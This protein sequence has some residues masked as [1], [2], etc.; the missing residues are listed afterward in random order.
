MNSLISFAAFGLKTSKHASVSTKMESAPP[1]PSGLISHLY[2][3]A[4]HWVMVVLLLLGIFLAEGMQPLLAQGSRT[5]Y[6]SGAT[7]RRAFLQSRPVEKVPATFNPFPNRGTHRVWV[8]EGETIYVGSSMQGLDINANT[9]TGTIILRTPNGTTY[10]SGTSTTVGLIAN[11]TEELAGPDRPGVTAGYTPYTRTVLAGEA[12]IWEID[13]VSM[14]SATTNSGGNGTNFTQHTTGGSPDRLFDNDFQA[15]FNWSGTGLNG[16]PIVENACALILAW[17]VSVTSGPTSGTLIEGRVFFTN[18]TLTLPNNYPTNGGFYGKTYLLTKEG[19]SYSIEGNNLNGAS[20][21]VFS[22]N[23]GIVSGGTATP[24]QGTTGGT[25]TYLSEDEVTISGAD[26][27]NT[28]DPRSADGSTDFTNLQFYTKPASD[29]PATAPIRYYNTYASSPGV[30]IE[31]NKWIKNTPLTIT[32]SNYTITDVTT[33]LPNRVGPAGANVGFTTN[34]AGRY[35]MDIDGNDDGDFTDPIDRRIL[36]NAIVGANTFFWDGKDGN[37]NALASNVTPVLRLEQNFLGEIHIPMVDVEINPNGIIV[38]RLDANYDPIPGQDLL[39]WNDENISNSTVVTNPPYPSNPVTNTVTGLSSTTNGH[40]FGAEVPVTPFEGCTSCSATLNNGDGKED[41]GNGKIINS[42]TRVGDLQELTLEVTPL[43][44]AALGIVKTS[45]LPNATNG[46]T[47]TYT[48]TVTGG[49]I[50]TANNVTLTDVLPSGLTYVANSTV[51]SI[52]NATVVT[53]RARDEFASQAY[54]LNVGTVNFSS[55][56]IESGTGETPTS[57]SVGTI[58]VNT[59]NGNLQFQGTSSSPAIDRGINLSTATSAT[60]SFNQNTTAL[61]V[62]ETLTFQMSSNG[63]TYNTINTFRGT[64]GLY[65]Y[66]VPN[67]YFTANARIRFIKSSWS[68]TVNDNVTIDN[69]EVEYSASSTVTTTRNNN[70]SGTQLNSGLPATLITVADNIDLTPSSV[71]T[72]TFMYTVG[73]ISA[74]TFVNTATANSTD[75]ASSVSATHTSNYSNAAPTFTTSC[76]ADIDAT[77]VPGSCNVTLTIPGVVATDDC[78]SPTITWALT[79]ATTGNGTG[80][81][82]SKTFLPGETLITYTATDNLGQTVTCSFTVTVD[83]CADL[84][85]VKDLNPGQDATPPIG[86]S[87]TFRIVVTNNGVNEASLVTL[88]DQLPAGIT[89]TGH[90]VTAGNYTSGTGV[91]TGFSLLPAG[92]ATLL[93]TGTVNDGFGG[94]TITNNTTKATSIEHDPT[95]AGNDLTEPVN[96]PCASECITYRTTKNGH[97][98]DLTVWEVQACSGIWTAAITIPVQGSQVNIMDTIKQDVNFIVEECPLILVNNGES[99]LIIEPDITLG[100]NGG[101]DGKAYFNNRPVVVRSTINGTGAIGEVVTNSAITGEENVQLERFLPD[102]KRRWNLLTP[103]VVNGTTINVNTTLR[104]A[105]AGGTQPRVTSS[106]NIS[107]TVRLPLGNPYDKPKNMPF[108][109]YANDTALLIH[110]PYNSGYNPVNYT[111]YTGTIITGHR[112]ASGDAASPMGFDWWPELIIPKDSTFW[113]SPGNPATAQNLRTTPASIRPYRPNG[114]NDFGPERGTSWVSNADINRVPGTGGRSIVQ[115]TL[116]EL[117]H[118][119]MLFTRG[120]RRVLENWYDSTTLRPVGKIRTGDVEIAVNPSGTQQLTVLPNPYPAPISLEKLYADVDANNEDVMLGKAHI[121]Y[122]SMAGANGFGGWVTLTR[123]GTNW[124]AAPS[125][126]NNSHYIS[127]SQAFMVEGTTGGGNLTFKERMKVD[128]NE[129]E[130]LPFE[131]E[132]TGNGGKSGVLITNLNNRSN[133]NV[134]SVVDGAGI[135]LDNKFTTATTDVNDVKKVFNFEGGKSLSLKRNGETL[136]FDAH[137]DPVGETVFPLQANELAKANYAFT[138]HPTDLEKDGREAWLK[139]KFLGTETPISL[140]APSQYNFEGTTDAASVSPERFEIVFK[141]GEVLPVTF[142]SIN[143]VEQ[144]K[145]I[146]VSWNVATEDKMSHYEV[147]HSTNGT[148]FGKAVKVDAK[149]TSPASYNWLHVQPGSGDHFYR[150]RAFNLE[151]RSLLTK[152][153]KVTLGDNA[154]GFKAFPTVVSATRQVTLQLISLDKGSYTLQVTDMAGKVISARTIEHGG[155]SASMI[156][157]MPPA[158]SAGKYNIRLTGKSGNFVQPV[159]K[160]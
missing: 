108:P 66:S 2:R 119:Y 74:S 110:D 92:T 133:S 14:E 118:G 10:T 124:L 131:N 21:S 56:W 72:V 140:T 6:P 129:I 135:L 106:N 48:I 49:G 50:G 53:Q 88:T 67:T 3:P 4:T 75:L 107:G 36:I 30:V 97:W 132:G 102:P 58:T 93:L 77:P 113:L 54:N 157:Q 15:N 127:S 78:G 25:A 84:V 155:G 24:G 126:A 5:L 87:V 47:G 120:D 158:L 65:T 145:N 96:V 60:V 116:N 146:K 143:A 19:Y 160:D 40:K 136:A 144:G 68:G 156:M 115:L 130:F 153:V 20:W 137:P 37:G 29:L 73:C 69:V 121:W 22:N 81:V 35:A 105:W 39:Y 134:L 76:P 27:P 152:V 82:G 117:D 103:G 43:T 64:S 63:T 114:S 104:D 61:E 138:F 125:V 142:T 7:G 70:G 154:P 16:Q 91:W 85:T 159:V 34:M 41:F 112:N 149:N 59:T 55:N 123:N 1:R 89:Y 150:V 11:R 80:A 46:A 8:K 79:G 44:G 12:G 99:K 139:D 83:P 13:F 42:W 71:L 147:E 23:K 98:S 95:D 38:K 100:F 52:Q 57:A 111:P 151:G 148:E 101:T 90:T 45:N 28:H 17:D 94:T 9:N 122:S 62:G 33:G 141:Q 31:A 128:I 32:L 26:A 18:L 109:L 86:S 51:A